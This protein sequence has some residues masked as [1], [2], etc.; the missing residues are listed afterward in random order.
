MRDSVGF[1]VYVLTVVLP[2]A[3]RQLVVIGLQHPPLL[4]LG[5]FALW[6]GY[7]VLDAAVRHIRMLALLG[8]S[9]AIVVFLQ[10]YLATR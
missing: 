9:Y 8:A 7:V 2:Y 1:V 3:I 10:R 6:C 4:G 5:L